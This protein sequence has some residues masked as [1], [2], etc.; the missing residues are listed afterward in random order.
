[1][2]DPNGFPK[3][4]CQ[5]FWKEIKADIMAFMREFHARGKLSKNIGA[6]FIALIPK[7]IGPDCLKDFRSIN[8]IGSLQKIFA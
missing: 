7:K 5:K 4:F 1:M 2:P 6:S 8:L 3:A